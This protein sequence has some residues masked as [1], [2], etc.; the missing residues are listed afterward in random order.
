[1]T[2]P[3]LALSDRV[4]QL[5]PLLLI[6]AVVS[7]PQSAQ[8]QEWGVIRFAHAR[9]NVRASR[10]TQSRIVSQLTPG[11]R[12][13]ADYLEDNW[14]AVF[15]PGDRVRA[16]SRAMGYVYAPLLKPNPPTQES[17]TA[18]TA[19]L[20]YRVVKRQDV[21]YLGSQR[22]VFRVLLEVDQVPPQA[23]MTS[24][25]ERLWQD[26]NRGWDEFTVFLYLPEMNT[27]SMAYGVG[28]F[29]KRGLKEFKINEYA[30]GG[31]KW[32]Q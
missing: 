15:S 21:S 28:E 26:G 16:E 6:A 9:V 32:K 13:R 3:R 8:A 2:K 19:E 7:L 12:V 27:N 17:I 31:T 24:V 4:R 14:F 22:M 20:R 23:A 10:S 5:R 25:A 18:S 11:Q 1:M 29:G 30:L